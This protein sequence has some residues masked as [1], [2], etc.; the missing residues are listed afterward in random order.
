MEYLHKNREEFNEADC[1][2]RHVCLNRQGRRKKRERKLS[3]QPAFSLILI[4]LSI[5]LSENEK[6][7]SDLVLHIFSNPD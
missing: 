2:R 4:R 1:R 7:L 6:V 5:F 3:R